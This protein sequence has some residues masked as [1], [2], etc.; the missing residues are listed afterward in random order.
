MVERIMARH[1]MRGPVTWFLVVGTALTLALPASA[2][3]FEDRYPSEQR[4]RRQQP[5]QRQQFFPFPFFNDRQQAPSNR[6][7][8]FLRPAQQPV[9][10]SKAPPSR[11][12]DTT[13]TS[14]VVVIGDS[15]A[16]WLGYGLD[17]ALS[18]TPEIGVVRKIRA[19]S[20]L[21]RYEPRSET[22][23]WSQALKDILQAEK[24]SAI[25]VMLGLND[26]QS[27]RDRPP[28]QPQT[29]Q[30]QPPQTPPNGEQPPA[31]T[32]E[33]QRPAPTA[34]GATYEF[35][36]DKWAEAYGKRIDE[37]IAALKSKGAP[38]LWVGLP[39]I[40]GQRATSDESYLDDLYRT[41]AEKAGI[42]Y[43]DV[44]DGFVDESG[45]YTVEGPDFEGQIR[46]LRSADGVHFTK[47]GAIKLAHYVERE[48]RRAL[49]RSVVPVALPAPD[50][51]APSLATPGGGPAPRPVAGPVVPLN[52][53]SGKDD[54]L[55]GGGGRAAT[56][57][58][59][60]DPT[61]SRVLV[62]G[63]A[64]APPRGRADD[65]A[66]PPPGAGAVPDD[67]PAPV[68][69]TA[70][71]PVKPGAKAAAVPAD[72]KKT[73]A[74]AKNPPAP[75]AAPVRTRKSPRAELSNP[76]RPPANVGMR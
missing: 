26:R 46:R 76:P 15:M 53:N 22:P 55:L 1:G 57:A 56:P 38:V 37:M 63:E 39:S 35:R 28:Q 52:T 25:V 71:A 59:T 65:F 42:A 45:R 72:G 48:L 69:T 21:I 18:D 17:E 14:T 30:A 4:S 60:P 33:V 67:E 31:A 44:W 70:P 66:W 5:Q 54:E 64:V 27:I 73:K 7:P 9:D 20:G 34:A 29:P 19:N 40:R 75:D 8:G 11:K 13:P 2:Q 58:P 61:A 10:S 36:T 12:Q 68:A 32:H 74:D 43:V 24:P 16:D 62:R 41:R 49:S 51:P 47:A 3:F 50:E 6:P 23:D